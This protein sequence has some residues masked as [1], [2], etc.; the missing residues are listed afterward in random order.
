MTWGAVGSTAVSV[1]G[2][3]LFGGSKEGER[4]AKDEAARG[5]KAIE[6]AKRQARDDLSPYMDTGANAS[7][8]LSELL[9]TADPT[10]YAKRPQLQDFVDERRRKHYLKFG[11]DY[12]RNSNMGGEAVAAK[13]DY[14]RALKSW[15]EGKAKYEA[16]NP[17]S[18]GSGDLLKAFTNEDFVRDPG[19][20]ARLMEGE[21]GNFRSLAAGGNL[22]S[23]KALKALERYRQDYAS[24]EF[25]NAFNRDSANKSRTYSFLSGAAGQGLNAAGTAIGVNTNAARDNANIGTNVTNQVNQM[26]QNRDDNQSNLF[27]SAIGNLIYGME[28]N[29]PVVSSGGY[30]GG[31][32]TPPFNPNAAK[33]WYLS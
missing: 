1:I 8:K 7:R 15:E 19:Y 33:P 4:D 11:S 2:G 10:G 26:Q 27:Q 6:D 5:Q 17:S 9:G 24:N 32:S 14:E 22:A 23:G 13:G 16:Q 12:T 31:Y 25:G 18:R 30:T 21:K 3:S 20:E 28:R 29:K